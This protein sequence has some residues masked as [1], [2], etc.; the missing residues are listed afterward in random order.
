MVWENTPLRASGALAAYAPSLEIK[1][2]LPGTG[3]GFF[4]SWS[5]TRDYFAALISMSTRRF[6]ARPSAVLLSATGW[7]SPLPCV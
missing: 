5:I 7:L 3:S 1:N 6:L 4:Y 2:P